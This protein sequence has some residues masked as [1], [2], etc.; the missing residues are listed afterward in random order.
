[1]KG[2]NMKRLTLHIF[3]AL[4]TFIIGVAITASTQRS[5]KKLHA[6]DIPAVAQTPK[7]PDGYVP[8]DVRAWRLLLSFENQ[9]LR[10]LDKQAVIRLQEAIG[11]LTGEQQPS[12][13][14]FLIL[15]L[16]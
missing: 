1:V 9:D 14:P 4:L 10:R 16:Q 11:I 2:E 15:I 6:A 5:D 12:K 13:Y 3:V 7:Q 8:A